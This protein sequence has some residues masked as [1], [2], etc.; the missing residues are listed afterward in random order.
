MGDATH[1]GA[2]REGTEPILRGVQDGTNLPRHVGQES[3]SDPGALGTRCEGNQ[4]AVFQGG[5]R[6]GTVFLLRLQEP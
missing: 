1:S 6:W 4:H 2:D 3:D 5:V